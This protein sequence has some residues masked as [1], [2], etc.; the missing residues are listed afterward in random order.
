MSFTRSRRRSLPTNA[1][2][3]PLYRTT[4]HKKLP[5]LSVERVASTPMGFSPKAGKDS[6][7]GCHS[8]CLLPHLPGSARRA[9]RHSLPPVLGKLVN[10]T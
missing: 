3:G 7:H 1:L 2:S 8:H 9:R 5:H 6:V 10:T 4:S